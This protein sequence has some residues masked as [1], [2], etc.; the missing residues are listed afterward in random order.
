MGPAG[1]EGLF[2]LLPSASLPAEQ[3]DPV[4]NRGRLEFL[5]KLEL[6]LGK[7]RDEIG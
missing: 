3:F 5:P 6:E 4:D 2:N 7:V 1:P